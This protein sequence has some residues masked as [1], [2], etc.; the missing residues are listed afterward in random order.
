MSKYCMQC[1]KQIEDNANHC[2]FCG[3]S[4]DMGFDVTAV[5]GTAKKSSSGA[6][7]PV[8]AVVSVI[9][10]VVIVL[11]NLTVFNNGYEEPIEN[12][13]D[14]IEEGD[15]DYLEDALP[16]YMDIDSEKMEDTAKKL[17][18]AMVVMLGEDFEI[19]FDV[20]DKEEIDDKKLKKLEKSIKEDFDEDV[21]VDAGYNVEIEIFLEGDD[22]D[23]S[24]KTKIPV[25]KIDGDWCITEDISSG[26]F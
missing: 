8:V 18:A 16:E 5:N 2:Q 10:V 24:T 23:E 13:F 19:D 21:D 9:L 3:A 7:V 15:G 6:L 17:K 20:I 1:G 22:K 26:I 12:L 4:Q 14:A 25:Y 11:L